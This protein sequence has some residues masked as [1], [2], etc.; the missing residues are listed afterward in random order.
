MATFLCLFRAQK[1][2]KKSPCLLQFPEL[3]C[4][5]RL[6]IM[7]RTMFIRLSGPCSSAGVLI[8]QPLDVGQRLLNA[9]GATT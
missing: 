4:D 1:K 5:P 8:V 6:V 2:N 9:L 3:W 7:S